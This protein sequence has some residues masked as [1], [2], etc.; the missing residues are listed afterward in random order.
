M[1]RL[2][3]RAFISNP[4][5]YTVVHHKDHNTKN[6]C[7]DNL[8][9][10]NKEEHDKIHA[11]ERG[12]N[13]IGKFNGGHSKKVDIYSTDEKFIMSF[14]SMAEGIRYLKSNGCICDSS[15]VTACCK[16]KQK[17]AYGYIWKYSEN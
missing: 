4:N 15:N 5:G 10:V 12:N 1:H 2:V 3:A 11:R 17:S 13:Q 8:E 9:W 14:P 7:V 16:G 6:N